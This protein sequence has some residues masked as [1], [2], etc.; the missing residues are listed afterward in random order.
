MSQEGQAL[1]TEGGGIFSLA[2]ASGEDPGLPSCAQCKQQQTGGQA[3]ALSFH[4]TTEIKVSR[5]DFFGRVE[6]H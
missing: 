5:V 1:D 2:G 6:G 4:R 3:G